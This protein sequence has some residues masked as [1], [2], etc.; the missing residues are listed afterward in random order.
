VHIAVP[1]RFHYPM[2]KKALLAG[3]HVMCEK[4][5]AMN[6]KESG[7]LVA[8]ARKTRLAAGV[9]YNVRYYPLSIQAREMVRSGE[10]GRIYS[11]CGSYAQDWLLYPTDY[12]WRVLAKEGGE[13]RAVADIGTH[14]LDL[15]HAITGWRWKRC[16]RTST[17][18]T[19]SGIAPRA[20]SRRSRAR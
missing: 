19:R 15:V 18:C 4:P 10:I 5:L 1:N 14:W 3:K 13:L 9:N 7:E 2:A 17:P 16:A 6:S 12:N 8:L 20:R 11:V